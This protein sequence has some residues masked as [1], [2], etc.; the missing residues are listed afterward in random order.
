MDLE[1]IVKRIDDLENQLASIKKAVTGQITRSNQ[2]ED[3]T[4]GF[5]DKVKEQNNEISRINSILSGLGQ[6][7]SAITK[8]RIDLNRQI[9]EAEKRIQLNQKMLDKI[10]IEEIKSINATI[11]QVKKDLNQSYNQKL[12]LLNREDAKQT[13]RIKEVENKIDSKINN[14]EEFKVN[15]NILQQ[16]VRQ[17]KKILDGLTSEVEVFMKRNDE[18]RTRLDII[19]RDMKNYDN[20]LNEIIAT[21]T[22]R[23]QSYISFMEQ[24]SLSKNERERIWEEWTTQF[25]E[26]ISQIYKVLPE[27]QS[28]QTEMKKSK[29]LF[30]EISQKFDRRAN[31]IT[32]MYRL[33]DDKFRKEWATFKTDMEKRWSNVSLIMED[34]QGGSD[35]KFQKI[36]ERIVEVEDDTQEMQEALLLMSR[37]IQKGMQSL[38]NMVNGWMDAFGEIKSQ[39]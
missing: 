31:E 7:D 13:L 34:K 26:T 39:R 16:E 5:L 36:N 28:Q 37:E 10:R 15:I 38:M 24:Q 18:S 6:F 35:D 19:N 2:V 33:M 4:M 21:E 23:K 11:E 3:K 8:T 14:E 17:N 27:L 9:E 20:R 12:E 1:T 22:E 29:A 25:E 32:E 30:E